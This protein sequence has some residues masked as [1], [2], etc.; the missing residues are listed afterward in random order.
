MYEI[1]FNLHHEE[2]EFNIIALLMTKLLLISRHIT[3][4]SKCN[5]FS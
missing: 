5:S 3:V 2:L 1:L 4:F